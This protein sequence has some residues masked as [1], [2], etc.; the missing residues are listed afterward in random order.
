MDL[1]DEVKRAKLAK[2]GKEPGAEDLL[3]TAAVV[4]PGGAPAHDDLSESKAR[5]KEA[6]IADTQTAK[7]VRG[8]NDVARFFPER[9]TYFF[10]E[11][12]AVAF[13]GCI[14]NVGELPDN[15]RKLGDHEVASAEMIGFPIGNEMIVGVLRSGDDVMLTFVTDP[16]RMGKN[17]D[18]RQWL[19][20]ELAAWG[21]S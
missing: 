20:E 2:V 15:F 19:A 18:L 5:M 16:A 14:S 21:I 4:L 8:A 6:Y 12:A 11:K 3:L 9:L 1:P 7:A 17:K 10:A 13:D